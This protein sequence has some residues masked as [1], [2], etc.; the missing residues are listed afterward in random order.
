VV[1]VRL[2]AGKV[3]IPTTAFVRTLIA[4]RLAADVCVSHFPLQ[5]NFPRICAMHTRLIRDASFAAL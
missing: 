1:V 4:A 5:S 3:L 2:R